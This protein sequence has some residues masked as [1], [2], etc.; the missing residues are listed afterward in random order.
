MAQSQCALKRAG[1]S[2]VSMQSEAWPERAVLCF[3]QVDW[4]GWA[5]QDRT[6]MQKGAVSADASTEVD[7]AVEKEEGV[8]GP[9]L[10][11]HPL[12]GSAARGTK[13][14]QVLSAPPKRA[15]CMGSLRE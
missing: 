6:P 9:L 15:P 7:K 1:C 13:R 12:A 10:T 14:H 4:T 3:A 11:C 8:P 5:E 2:K